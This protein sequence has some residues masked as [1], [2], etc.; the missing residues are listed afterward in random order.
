[1]CNASKKN[2]EV[3][4]NMLLVSSEVLFH[5]EIYINV[6]VKTRHLLQVCDL[7][8]TDLINPIVG[9]HKCLV[10]KCSIDVCSKYNNNPNPVTCCY[11]LIHSAWSCHILWW[12]DICNIFLIIIIY[13]DGGRENIMIILTCVV[14]D[15]G[16]VTTLWGPLHTHFHLLMPVIC[17]QLWNQEQMK[18][19][20]FSEERCAK[21][22]MKSKH[23]LYQ[24]DIYKVWNEK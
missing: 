16:K 24:V 8:Y 21:F 7:C 10:L 13:F 6:N 11:H 15:L 20:E 12:H 14:G 18:I 4:Y 22:V 2:E 9:V 19:K 17:T 5:L 1:M 3:G 23:Y